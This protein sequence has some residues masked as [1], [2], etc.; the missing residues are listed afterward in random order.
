MV[1]G[2]TG[3]AHLSTFMCGHV[4]AQANEALSGCNPAVAA[5]AS[6]TF[7]QIARVNVVSICVW[8]FKEQLSLSCSDQ[9]RSVEQIQTSLDPR[10]LLEGVNS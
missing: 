5:V 2:E 7:G 3:G 9:E 4:D 6:F 1:F 8:V 10:S